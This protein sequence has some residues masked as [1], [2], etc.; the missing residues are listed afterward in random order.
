MKMCRFGD[1][2]DEGYRKTK[3]V[4]SLYLDEIRDAKLRESTYY[5]GPKFEN[6]LVLIGSR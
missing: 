3:G 1:E 4:V 2:D 6:G 5:D